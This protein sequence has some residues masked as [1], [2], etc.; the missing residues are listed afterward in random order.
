MIEWPRIPAPNV[1][2]SSGSQSDA[3]AGN[4]MSCRK[5]SPTSRQM[6]AVQ[7][8]VPTVYSCDEI[9]PFRSL[10]E[11]EV[12]APGE[13][14]ADRSEIACAAPLRRTGRLDHDHDD[15]HDR[16]CRSCDD[17][18]AGSA[19]RRT[20]PRRRRR[21]A[22]AATPIVVAL[23]TFVSLTAV[24]KNTTSKPRLIAT[25]QRWPQHASIDPRAPAD[26]PP[27]QDEGVE[28]RTARNRSPIHSMSIAL[29][30]TPDAPQ[31]MTAMPVPSRP[32]FE[33]R[34]LV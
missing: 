8:P 26:H 27:D 32:S 19:R 7:T 1:S 11:D 3:R 25:R 14:G 24:K 34:A 29:I 10:R 4:D 31:A 20:S 5:T 6:I 28:R 22:A 30:T 16:D 13:Q 12:A 15:G 17:R 18:L 33:S 23:T 2:A 21:S 9:T